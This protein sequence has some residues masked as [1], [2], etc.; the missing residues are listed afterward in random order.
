MERA[1][2]ATIARI[3]DVPVLV[4]E[5]WDPDECPVALLPWLA[6][7][8]SVDEWDSAW[9]EEEKRQAVRDAYNLARVKGTVWAVK[10]QL[11]LLGYPDALLDEGTA[12]IL[13]EVGVSWAHYRVRF[14]QLLTVTQAQ[15]VA[16]ALEAAA[17]KRSQLWT[18]H[19]VD[20]V[21]DYDGTITAD[22]EYTHGEYA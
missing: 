19:F 7:A 1:L 8:F 20:H 5:S 4:R 6:W 3:S 21:Y 10:R 2:E 9:T 15:R 18:L 12:G 13:D 22:G 16:R 14:E 11:L 17:P